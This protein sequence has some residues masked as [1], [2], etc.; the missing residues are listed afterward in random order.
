MNATINSE[1]NYDSK[2]HP[3][4]TAVDHHLVVLVHASENQFSIVLAAPP[5]ASPASDTI[6][7][8]SSA[9]ADAYSE[10]ESVLHREAERMD[11]EWNG[12]A[13]S[14]R[15]HID[16]DGKDK[17]HDDDDDKFSEHFVPQFV[18][19]LTISVNLIYGPRI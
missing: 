7:L 4:P 8:A 14:L 2:V 15:G 12:K 18:I 1:G 17:C 10:A 9:K 19:A 13:A 6:F 11:T 5:I 16:D 3:E